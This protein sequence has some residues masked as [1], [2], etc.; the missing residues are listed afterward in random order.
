MLNSYLG[1]QVY[2]TKTYPFFGSI[3][4]ITSYGTM[5]QYIQPTITFGHSLGHSKKKHRK[6]P[7]DIWI[8]CREMFG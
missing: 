7:P 5:L 6:K 4:T 3:V 8:V 1:T 2:L